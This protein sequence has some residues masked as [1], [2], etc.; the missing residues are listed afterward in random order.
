MPSD[1]E[2]SAASQNA[3]S[4]VSRR[5]FLQGAGLAAAE[6]LLPRSREA[7][8]ELSAAGTEPSQ[9]LGPDAVALLLNINGKEHPLLVEP[10]ITLAEALRSSLGMTGTKLACDRGACGSCTVLLDGAPVHSCMLLAVEIGSRQIRT[11]EGL[12]LGE[13]LHPLQVE[14]I[15]QGA[16][17]CGFC[18]PGMIMTCTA[19]LE[20]RAKPS[21]EDVRRAISGNLCRCGTYTRVCEATLTA[22]DQLKT[23]H[24]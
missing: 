7:R 13:T 23:K 8:A 18:T 16:V 21:Y 12:A 1:P 17:Q 14:F 4:G 22:A 15:R 2:K 20:R 5:G 6:A 9:A 10:R 24:S 19:L 11:I 3:S